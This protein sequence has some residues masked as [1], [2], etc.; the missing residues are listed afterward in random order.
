VNNVNQ[1]GGME[2]NYMIVRALK[3]A[4]SDKPILLT[5]VDAQK[6]NL[7]FRRGQGR[8]QINQ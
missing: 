5:D 2:K 1:P 7:S 4:C 6:R 8:I 3:K